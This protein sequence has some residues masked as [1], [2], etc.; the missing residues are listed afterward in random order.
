MSVSKLLSRI[1]ASED[2]AQTGDG[3]AHD[4]TYGIASD[5][6]AQ[7]A[8]V[9]SALVHDVDHS[10][11]PN[12]ILIKENATLAKKYRNKSVAEANSTDL[13]WTKLLDPQFKQL[14]ECIY[15]NTR[16]LLRF[17]RLIV[18]TVLATDIFDKQLSDLR[19]NRWDK[20]FSVDDDHCTSDDINRRGTIVIEHLIQASDVAHTMQHY[21]IFKKWNERL[22]REMYDAYKNGRS[23]KNP[24]DGWY[25][26]ELG[27]FDHYV[28]PLAKKLKECG[29][30]GVSSDEYLNYALE[31]RREWATKGK[32]AVE[33]MK[34]SYVDSD[35]DNDAANGR[36]S[37]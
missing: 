28:I 4:G 33:Q 32:E 10:G 2:L 35:N 8:I 25:Q 11:V 26:G 21:Q 6:L 19:R 23:D 9:L 15:S 16:E 37:T 36:T 7:F 29:V 22:F 27:F 1:V 30:F 17:R 34:A 18:N 13:A 20:A 12:F 3:N 14:R 5:P 31:N 24:I